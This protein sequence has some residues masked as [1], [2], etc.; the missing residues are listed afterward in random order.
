MYSFIAEEK[1]PFKETDRLLNRAG[2]PHNGLDISKPIEQKWKGVLQRMKIM[3]FEFPDPT[4]FGCAKI[5]EL[6]HYYDMH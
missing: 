4:V 6:F 2:D 5:T 1:S 3:L